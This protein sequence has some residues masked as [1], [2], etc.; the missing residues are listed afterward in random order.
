MSMALRSFHQLCDRWR[1]TY[2]YRYA[3]PFSHNW[4]RRKRKRSFQCNWTVDQ[5]RK[6]RTYDPYNRPSRC[7]VCCRRYVHVSCHRHLFGIGKKL[8]WYDLVLK[9]LIL[10][11]LHLLFLR[12][13]KLVA[14]APEL[15]LV[16]HPHPHLAL[17]LALYLALLLEHREAR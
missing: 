12:H 2:F 11:I 8:I 9:F 6:P 17:H 15:R 16:Q 10:R 1:H 4:H 14:A 7:P 3:G 13:R 5:F